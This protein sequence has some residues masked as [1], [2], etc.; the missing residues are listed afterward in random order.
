MNNCEELDFKIITIC[1]RFALNKEFEVKTAVVVSTITS[2]KMVEL[3]SRFEKLD[4]VMTIFEK[5]D[6]AEF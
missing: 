1:L 2:I 5:I 6:E 3:K 4:D